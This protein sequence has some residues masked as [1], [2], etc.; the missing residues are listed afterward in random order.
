[1]IVLA[2][3]LNHDLPLNVTVSYQDVSEITSQIAPI[4]VSPGMDVQLPD[5]ARKSSRC[6]AGKLN[7]CSRPGT[8]SHLCQ[9][10]LS[11]V[12]RMTSTTQCLIQS[13]LWFLE[14]GQRKA[15]P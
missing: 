8:N 5:T 6:I 1:M 13:T 11:N 2:E 10:S 3:A 14:L 9:T 12:H 4:S 7:T 15:N